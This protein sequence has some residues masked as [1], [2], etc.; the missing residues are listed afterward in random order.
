MSYDFIDHLCQW[1]SGIN[2]NRP[3]LSVVLSKI[4]QTGVKFHGK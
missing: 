2:S 1:F 4:K 3:K